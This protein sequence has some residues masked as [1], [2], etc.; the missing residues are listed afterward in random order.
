M[1]GAF[2]LTATV[3]APLGGGVLTGK[4]TRT[5]TKKGEV[6][7]KR[8]NDARLTERNL[9]IARAVDAI[10]D[11]LGCSSAQV[12]VN[13]A[14]Q[15]SANIIPIVGARKVE[16][17]TDVL[18]C[19]E[20]ELADEHQ[21]KLAELSRIELGFPHSFL[22]TDYVRKLVYGDNVDQIDLPPLA[23]PRA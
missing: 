23:L 11:E 17:I 12:A 13:W 1:A 19:L 4:H 15:R 8:S 9:E 21:V 16:Q 3:W 14:R 22:G 2:G 10:A 20:H 18:G 6:D 5:Q 7:S